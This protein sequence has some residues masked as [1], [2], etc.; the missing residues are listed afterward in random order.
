VIG[1]PLEIFDFVHQVRYVSCLSSY[2]LMLLLVVVVDFQYK[3]AQRHLKL[4]LHRFRQVVHYIILNLYLLRIRLFDACIVVF[5]FKQQNFPILHWGYLD[6]AEPLL[7]F[8]RLENE[9]DMHFS[10][11]KCLLSCCD[12]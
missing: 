5:V 11:C 7:S 10:F 3:L 8:N 12:D 4:S 2:I 1:L 6:V 9:V